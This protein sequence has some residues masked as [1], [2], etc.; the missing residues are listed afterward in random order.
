MLKYKIIYVIAVILAACMVVYANTPAALLLLILMALLPL[1]IKLSVKDNAKRIAI[2]CSMIDACVVGSATKPLVVTVENK[3]LL[4]MGNLEL[5]LEYTN[6]MFGTSRTEEV[7]LCGTGRRL[8][9]ELP[10]DVDRCGRSEVEIK[11]VYCFDVLNLMRN[12][13][14][15]HWRKRYTI[16][17]AMHEIQLHAHKLL[18]AEFGG[19]NYDRSRRGND[20]SEVFQVRE[21]EMGDNL[22]AAHWKLSA[23]SDEIII[24]EWSRP[25]N[26]R[27]LIL[28]DI[29]KK[30]IRGT[31]LSFAE[32]SAIMGFTASLSRELAHQG[33]GHNVIMLNNGPIVDMSIHQE[34][35]SEILLDDIMSVVVPDNNNNIYD[36]II[37]NNIQNSFSKLVYIGPNTN[38]AMLHE[39]SAYMDVTA[40]AIKDGA[41]ADF[42][43]HG[44]FAVYTM[45]PEGIAEKAQFVEL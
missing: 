35:D 9:F 45:S 26:F 32:Q 10:I 30:D 19:Q 29:V 12:R 27:I 21:Y 17:P 5:V 7:T 18:T 20:N 16:Y 44:Q 3:S 43:S 22:S 25:N 40:I 4:P 11:E 38:A 36:E 42:E 2:S 24:R 15:F 39:L 41:A 1:V 14:D 33:I 28:F 23:K 31:E 8:S 13:I 6:R 37:A 34:D